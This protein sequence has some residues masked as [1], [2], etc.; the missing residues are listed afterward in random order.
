MVPVC[1][2]Q[3]AVAQRPGPTEARGRVAKCRSDW[4]RRVY[5]GVHSSFG[6]AVWVESTMQAQLQL[7]QSRPSTVSSLSFSLSECQI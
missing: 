1:I 2:S 3:A 6:L 4:T 5:P 7:G